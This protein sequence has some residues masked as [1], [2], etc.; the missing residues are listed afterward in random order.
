MPL[1]P[2]RAPSANVSFKATTADFTNLDASA[3]NPVRAKFMSGFN[4]G[5]RHQR[6]GTQN[7][8]GISRASRS[9]PFLTGY[10]AGRIAHR[11]R[12]LETSQQVTQ[13]L[14]EAWKL[15]ISTHTGTDM[16]WD[17]RIRSTAN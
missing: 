9:V 16:S 1:A 8:E 3:A 17:S 2:Q 13:A 5:V 14:D 7:L 6:E 10:D 11:I 4:S 12:K 15:Y